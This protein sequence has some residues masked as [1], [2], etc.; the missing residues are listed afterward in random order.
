MFKPLQICTPA[1]PEEFY[2]MNKSHW[3]LCTQFYLK[4][5]TT[6]KYIWKQCRNWWSKLGQK[7]SKQARVKEAMHSLLGTQDDGVMKTPWIHSLHCRWL[8][9]STAIKSVLIRISLL[10]ST[11]H[12]T[13]LLRHSIHA[14]ATDRQ[15]DIC[16]SQLA[17]GWL[18]SSKEVELNGCLSK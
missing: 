6:L 11:V 13:L 16:L 14:R 7:E 15:T 17:A 1:C 5:N 18:A 9:S 12:P 4:T 10:Y 3:H 8:W 2:E